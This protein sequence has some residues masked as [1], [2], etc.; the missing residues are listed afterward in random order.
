MYKQVSTQSE[1]MEGLKAKAMSHVRTFLSAKQAKDD[2][3]QEWKQKMVEF[4]LQLESP[5]PDTSAALTWT[6]SVLKGD[7]NSWPQGV[8]VDHRFV[9]ADFRRQLIGDHQTLRYPN[10]MTDSQ[11]GFFDSVVREI[12]NASN[13]SPHFID[14]H[15]FRG[16]DNGNIRTWNGL[17]SRE[18]YKSKAEDLHR[19]FSDPKFKEDLNAKVIVQQMDAFLASLPKE[20]TPPPKSVTC[21]LL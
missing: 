4:S 2:F 6:E 7:P 21:T 10:W 16:V 19:R 1:A 18:Y 14:Y 3:P 12:D 20:K 5:N 15:S 8:P 9:V 11:K 17:P 13:G